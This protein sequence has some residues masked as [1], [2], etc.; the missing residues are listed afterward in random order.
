MFDWN[1]TNRG[2]GYSQVET[3]GQLSGGLIESEKS[4]VNFGVE[5]DDLEAAL[6]RAR[7]LS[8]TIVMPATDNGWVLKAQV[9]DPG[10][11]V[12]LIQV[13]EKLSP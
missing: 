9:Q 7:E 13:D 5:V 12:S 11:V 2:G 6:N 10:N 1:I 4:G 8:G 3:G